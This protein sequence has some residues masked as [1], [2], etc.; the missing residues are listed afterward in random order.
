MHRLFQAKAQQSHEVGLIDNASEK[1]MALFLILKKESS[2]GTYSLNSS[3]AWSSKSKYL[4][5]V[6]VGSF[7][8]SLT[9]SRI[10]WKLARPLC[11]FFVR[12]FS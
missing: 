8:T 1:R 4:L 6:G 7:M 9:I 11:D 2:I 10:V 3:C 5:A 12:T